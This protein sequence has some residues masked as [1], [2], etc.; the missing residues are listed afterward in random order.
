MAATATRDRSFGT[1]ARSPDR[2]RGRRGDVSAG[3]VAHRHGRANATATARVD[4]AEHGRGGVADRVEALDDR[5][6][7]AEDAAVGVD[8]A[9]AVRADGAGPLLDGAVHR[10]EDGLDRHGFG[11]SEGVRL[12]RVAPVRVLALLRV[13]V[14][15]LDG[16]VEGVGIDA[17]LH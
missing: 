9:A 16:G 15:A 7:V 3:P 10:T 17:D 12:V 14:V 5:R 1:V 2:P 11:A 13:L 6:A 4:R 8:P